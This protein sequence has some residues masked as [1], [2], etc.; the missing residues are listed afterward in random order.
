M[1]QGIRPCKVLNKAINFEGAEG[2]RSLSKISVEL[3]EKIYRMFKSVNSFVL[4]N[5]FCKRIH[6]F[7]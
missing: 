5:P 1:A 3:E 6:F 7:I 2:E 4:G